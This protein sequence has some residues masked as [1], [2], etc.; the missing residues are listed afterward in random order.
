METAFFYTE[1]E[2]DFINKVKTEFDNKMLNE[3]RNY[4]KEKNIELYDLGK[5]WDAIH[6]LI[7]GV[8]AI[9][10]LE[11]NPLSEAVMG[12]EMI[13]TNSCIKNYF[14][15][16]PADRVNDIINALDNISEK[17]F[18]ERYNPRLM[19]ENN[20]YPDIWMYEDEKETVKRIT[21]IFGNFKEFYHKV[22]NHNN[23]VIVEAK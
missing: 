13:V 10:I 12:T 16:I 17:Q 22:K 1:T 4:R 9:G 20:I 15:Y 6:F 11:N 18:K 5:M 23:G 19:A 7:T 2:T 3:Y 8:S 14:A 21:K